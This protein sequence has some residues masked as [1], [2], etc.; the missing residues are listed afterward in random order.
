MNSN[1]PIAARIP[2]LLYVS[3]SRNCGRYQSM[4]RFSG[5]AGR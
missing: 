4:L 2:V 5:S 1:D 3:L